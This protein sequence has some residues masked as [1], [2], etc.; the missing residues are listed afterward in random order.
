M[1]SRYRLSTENSQFQTVTKLVKIGGISIRRVLTDFVLVSNWQF[2]V[3]KPYLLII[4]LPR[5]LTMIKSFDPDEI[6]H[7]ASS[8]ESL[9]VLLPD[10][11]FFFWFRLLGSSPLRNFFQFL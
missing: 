10:F 5:F 9:E 4:Q 6:S 2:S 11:A 8:R 3:E 7:T 1:I